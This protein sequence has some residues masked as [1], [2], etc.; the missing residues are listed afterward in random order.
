MTVTGHGA[1]WASINHSR[2]LGLL[3]LGVLGLPRLALARGF[4]AAAIICVIVRSAAV[5]SSSFGCGVLCTALAFAFALRFD[6]PFRGRRCI[7]RTG[8]MS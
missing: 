7:E 8:A 3:R 1:L 4:F 5:G 2:G 6:T